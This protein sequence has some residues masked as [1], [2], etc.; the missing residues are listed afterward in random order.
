MKKVW[1]SIKEEPVIA[2]DS[3]RIAFM[4]RRSVL[5][6]QNPKLFY[7]CLESVHLTGPNINWERHVHALGIEQWAYWNELTN[8]LDVVLNR[9]EVAEV[10]GKCVLTV[11]FG[12]KP[13]LATRIPQVGDG[14]NYPNGKLHRV[15]G[16]RYSSTAERAELHVDVIPFD[17]QPEREFCIAPA[18]D[19]ECE[20][21]N[22][23]TVDELER[24]RENGLPCPFT[25]AVCLKPKEFNCEFRCEFYLKIIRDWMDEEENQ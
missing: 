13:P 6:C 8:R 21:C 17:Y 3:V 10:D 23:V 4:A 7:T 1:H 14:V 9:K 12:G 5:N 15:V 22:R 18:C 20:K 25:G 16:V 19:G 11:G 24:V 2:G